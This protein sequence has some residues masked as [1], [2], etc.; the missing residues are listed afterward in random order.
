VNEKPESPAFDGVEG[1]G[2]SLF[3]QDLGIFLWRGRF[4][5]AFEANQG[6]EI[7]GVEGIAADGLLSSGA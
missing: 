3:I 6:Q 1:W 7:S 4:F 2:R 5:S